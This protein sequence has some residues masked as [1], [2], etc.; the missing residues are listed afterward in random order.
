[1]SAWSGFASS[2]RTPKTVVARSSLVCTLRGVN[3]A[4]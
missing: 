1:L 4:Y 3:C 2:T